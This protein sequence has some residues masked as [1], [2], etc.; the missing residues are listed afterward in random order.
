MTPKVIIPQTA[1][2]IKNSQT[3]RL[4]YDNSKDVSGNCVYY[5]VGVKKPISWQDSASEDGKWEIVAVTDKTFKL[6]NIASPKIFL[7]DNP[8]TGIIGFEDNNAAD[9]IWSILA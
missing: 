6:R 4:L 5:N 9:G 1:I 7:Y 8:T 3:G 2:R